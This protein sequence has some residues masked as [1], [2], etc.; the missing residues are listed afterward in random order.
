[1]RRLHLYASEQQQGEV[2][3]CDDC[4]AVFRNVS[5]LTSHM[6]KFH[7]IDNMQ[8]AYVSFSILMS[9]SQLKLFSIISRI[10]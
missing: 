3:R 1:M 9:R 4:K 7:C 5:S 10:P 2:H 8:V 6:S